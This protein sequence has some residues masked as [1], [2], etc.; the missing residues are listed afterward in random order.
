M[1]DWYEW[2]VALL[3]KTRE[4]LNFRLKLVIE[5]KEKRR[6]HT[7]LDPNGFAIDITNVMPKGVLVDELGGLLGA[8]VEDGVPRPVRADT[9]LTLCS[10]RC[11]GINCCDVGNP[12]NAQD[13]R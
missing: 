7:V 10:P 2:N 4:A 9:K 1:V 6:K 3:F 8:R 11:L 12:S 13:I 5:T